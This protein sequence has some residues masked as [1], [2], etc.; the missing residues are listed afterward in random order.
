MREVI[1]DKGDQRSDTMGSSYTIEKNGVSVK[2]AGLPSLYC[3]GELKFNSFLPC[4]FLLRGLYCL[5]HSLPKSKQ[6][7]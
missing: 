3:T 6:N 4:G 7:V 1:V 2:A 5:E